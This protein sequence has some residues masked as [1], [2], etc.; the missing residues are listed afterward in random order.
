MRAVH[1]FHELFAWTFALITL[2]ANGAPTT[3]IDGRLDPTFGDV[4]YTVGD[5]V[6]LVGYVLIGPRSNF[7]ATRQLGADGILLLGFG[8]PSQGFR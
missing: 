2:M 5:K 8:V 3:A 4:S 7:A 6:L 1:K